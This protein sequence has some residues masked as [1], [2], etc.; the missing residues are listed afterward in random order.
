MK[1]C[2]FAPECIGPQVNLAEDVEVKGMDAFLEQRE[3]ARKIQDDKRE[4]EE[5]VFFK[6]LKELDPDQHYTIP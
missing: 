3:R 4:R 1:T 5:K 2:T 6:N